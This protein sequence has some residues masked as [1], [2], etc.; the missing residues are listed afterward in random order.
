MLD[1][2]FNPKLSD[3]GLA[4]LGANNMSNVTVMGT[5]GYCAPEYQKHGELTVKS[6]VYNFGVV[7]L[8]LISGR[9]ALDT[10]KPADEQ[11]LVTWAQ[12]IFRNPKR[13]PEMADPR[14]GNS[15]PEKSL[16]QAVGIVAMCLQDEPDVRPLISDVVASLAFLAI[17]QPEKPVAS[18][19]DHPGRPP[20]T[21][22]SPDDHHV[23]WT[24]ELKAQTSQESCHDETDHSEESSEA[25]WSDYEE[26]FNK[27]HYERQN[28]GMD[29]K[30]DSD[31]ESESSE[32]SSHVEE[33]IQQEKQKS[34]KYTSSWGHMDSLEYEVAS[35]SSSSSN[36]D[37]E[38]PLGS[39]DKRHNNQQSQHG[40]SSSSMKCESTKIPK[41]ERRDGIRAGSRRSS[42]K[43]G[44]PLGWK[45]RNDMVSKNDNVGSYSRKSSNEGSD[46]GLIY[47]KN[48]S[49]S[50]N[51]SQ[52]SIEGSENGSVRSGHH[53]DDEGL[54]DVLL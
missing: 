39:I 49:I 44:G 5:H 27:N 36:S 18:P 31:I 9:R 7:L 47:G 25:S 43:R 46:N 17:V 30:S 22:A 26:S 2:E 16:N 11:N 50:S 42:R 32:L 8:E 45:G 41:E 33:K 4:K 40:N 15:Y 23:R 34:V 21:K 19:D 20:E 6:D 29:E 12:P 48:H 35:M 38:S 24:P 1:E 3:Y 28:D 53:K 52:S 37:N 14:L 13:F 51:S 10:S 54:E